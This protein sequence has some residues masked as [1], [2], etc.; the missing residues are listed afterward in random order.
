MLTT[1]LTAI[2]NSPLIMVIAIVLTLSTVFYILKHT[3]KAIQKL[4]EKLSYSQEED[5]EGE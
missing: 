5:K 3:F 1:I 4:G 2:D